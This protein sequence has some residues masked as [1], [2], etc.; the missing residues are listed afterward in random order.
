MVGVS[1]N[2][3]LPKWQDNLLMAYERTQSGLVRKMVNLTI[4]KKASMLDMS[5]INLSEEYIKHQYTRIVQKVVQPRKSKWKF[6][7]FSL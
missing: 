6:E 4:A 7:S 3:Q 1:I 5:N 2:P